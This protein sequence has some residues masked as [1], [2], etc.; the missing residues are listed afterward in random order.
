M[1][2]RSE[3]YYEKLDWNCQLDEMWDGEEY[4]DECDEE[5]DDEYDY[6]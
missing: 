3:L 4:D 1:F 5:Y 2:D 6:E